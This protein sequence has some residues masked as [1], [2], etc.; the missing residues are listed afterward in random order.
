MFLVKNPEGGLYNIRNRLQRP[1]E[2]CRKGNVKFVVRVGGSGGK[3]RCENWERQI[4][5][6]A[7]PVRH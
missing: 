2:I 1:K 7:M 6:V 5:A 3:K 4:R